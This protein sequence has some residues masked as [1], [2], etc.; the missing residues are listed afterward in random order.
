M[1]GDYFS[2]GHYT[3]KETNTWVS[4]GYTCSTLKLTSIINKEHTIRR[5]GTQK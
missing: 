1:S 4:M 5:Q 3:A 2:A